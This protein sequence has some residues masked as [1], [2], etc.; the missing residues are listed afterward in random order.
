MVI[1]RCC[2]S[3]PILTLFMLFVFMY[4]QLMHEGWDN[5]KAAQGYRTYSYKAICLNCGIA[6]G[7]VLSG[8]NAVRTAPTCANLRHWIKLATCC[9]RWAIFDEIT[10]LLQNTYCSINQKLWG[11]LWGGGGCSLMC[12]G[13]IQVSSLDACRPDRPQPHH[14]SPSS[15]LPPKLSHDAQAFCLVEANEA[16]LTFCQHC[17]KRT[18]RVYMQREQYKGL[19]QC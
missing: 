10:M 18:C 2:D 19:K 9:C 5:E 8:G 17:P 12:M 3:V 11:E 14:V 16:R 4:M 7:I 15:P 1:V 6:Q 13:M